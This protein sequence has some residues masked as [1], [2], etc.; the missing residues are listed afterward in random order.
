LNE[1]LDVRLDIGP[2]FSYL[3]CGCG[4]LGSQV[5]GVHLGDYGTA[6]KGLVVCDDL[7]LVSDL[8]PIGIGVVAYFLLWRNARLRGIDLHPWSS[9][10]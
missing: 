8:S 9:P 10:E 4:D 7:N 3:G 2:W 6:W 1:L 5:A